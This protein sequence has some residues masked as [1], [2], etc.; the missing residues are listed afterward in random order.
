MLNNLALALK[1]DEKLDE[2]SALLTRALSVDQNNAQTLTYLALVRVQQKRIAEAEAAA[3]RALTLARDDPDAVNAMGLVRFEQQ[4]ADEAL[5]LFRRAIALKPELSD[6]HNNIGNI[7]KENGELAAARAAYERAIEI[8]PR[9][10]AYYVNLADL[11]KFAEGDAHL[12]A[13]EDIARKPDQLSGTMRGQLNFALCNAYEDLGRQDDAFGSMREAN[14]L[15]RARIEYDEARVLTMFDESA[16]HSTRM[17][18][19]QGQTRL[20]ARRCRYL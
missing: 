1:D 13:M 17:P 16:R 19:Q 3:Q 10:V 15:K 11:K 8:G 5:T 6:A 4:N 7:L 12:A 9:E 18:L 2:A 14:A 20:A